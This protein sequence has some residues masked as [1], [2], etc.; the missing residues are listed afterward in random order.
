VAQLRHKLSVPLVLA[1]K[2]V[3]VITLERVGD[4]PFDAEEVRLVQTLSSVGL[5][6]VSLARRDSSPI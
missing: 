2:V 3:A 5:L 4:V 1:A 6:A